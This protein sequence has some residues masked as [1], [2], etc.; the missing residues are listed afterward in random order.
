MKKKK[1]KKKNICLRGDYAEFSSLHSA[2]LLL[3]NIC[4]ELIS[5]TLNWEMQ[6]DYK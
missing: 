3:R 5:W 1:K 2:Q 4:W 6:K